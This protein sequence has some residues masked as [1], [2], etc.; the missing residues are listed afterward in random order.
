MTMNEI[1]SIIVVVLKP[2]ET[3]NFTMFCFP[4]PVCNNK[5]RVFH[6]GNSFSL[7]NT[8]MFLKGVIC[9]GQSIACVEFNT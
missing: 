9:A 5:S 4:I 8:M 2:S 3:L 6:P 1:S 7:F